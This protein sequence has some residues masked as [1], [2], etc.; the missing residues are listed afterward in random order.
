MGFLS[1]PNLVPWLIFR[2][3]IVTDQFCS[4]FLLLVFL[5]QIPLQLDREG[6]KDKTRWRKGWG[7]GGDYSREVIISNISIKG[8]GGDYSREA[9]NRGTANIRGNTVYKPKFVAHRFSVELVSEARKKNQS[10]FSVFFFEKIKWYLSFLF[11]VTFT[12]LILE[13]YSFIWIKALFCFWIF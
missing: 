6:I 12:T 5:Y 7:G 1:V 4:G 3:W 10:C 8:A 9:T 11:S 13:I 2:A